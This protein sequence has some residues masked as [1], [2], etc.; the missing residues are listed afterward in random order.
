ML[1]ISTPRLLLR[2]LRTAD[3]E[4]VLAY[5]SDPDIIRYQTWHPVDL[6]EIRDYIREQSGCIPGMP[7]I[8]YQLAI[9][10]LHS[11][12]LLGDCG[13]HVSLDDPASAEL[14]IT[15]KREAQH[16]GFAG[17]VLR[18][19]IGYCFS[20][21]HMHMITA[22]IFS[23]NQPALN[24]VER[25]GFVFRGRVDTRL[26]TEMEDCDLVYSLAS[27]TFHASHTIITTR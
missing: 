23:K 7:G 19:L 14:G 4:A 8:W 16:Q 24:L 12:D 13:V 21:M 9:I 3:A 18:G 5:R 10:S 26:D 11:D 15:L 22:R 20:T 25:N 1:T 27:A 6:R 2:P 17:E